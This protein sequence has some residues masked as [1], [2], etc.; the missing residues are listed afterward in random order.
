M[1]NEVAQSGG[2]GRGDQEKVIAPSMGKE[3]PAEKPGGPAL[4]PQLSAKS[5]VAE[6]YLQRPLRRSILRQPITVNLSRRPLWHPCTVEECLDVL[7]SELNMMV[8]S[9]QLPWAWDFG[10]GRQRKEMRI[11]GH[12][13][14][15]RTMGPIPGIGATKNLELPELVD[16]VLPQARQVFRS[17]ELQR[18]FHLGPEL[19]V[20]LGETG[21]IEK[22]PEE[23]SSKG[24]NA[25]PSFTRNSVA[26]LLAKRRIL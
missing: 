26:K 24:V 16:L 9:G 11:L 22:V 17:A 1:K 12:S 4:P 2:D 15:E 20:H 5:W 10:T 6:N 23:L 7:R 3:P 13:V 14:V 21:D 19:I 25:S 8:E 18:M